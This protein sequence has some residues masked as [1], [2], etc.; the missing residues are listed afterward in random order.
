[1]ILK[2]KPYTVGCGIHLNPHGNDKRCGQS[3]DAAG[4]LDLC[5]NCQV[6]QHA[7]QLM[8]QQAGKEKSA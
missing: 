6:R 5:D 7:N 4:F 8:D 3:K 2:T 1:M